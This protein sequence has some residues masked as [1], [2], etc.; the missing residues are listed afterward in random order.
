MD[1]SGNAYVTGLTTSID[2]PTATAL[3][4][5][6]KGYEN[7]FAIKLSATGAALVYST[8]LG[9]SGSDSG[10]AI[11][12]DA[13]GNAYVTGTTCSYDFPTANAFQTVNANPICGPWGGTAFVSKLSA[14]PA[15]TDPWEQAISAMRTAA[16]TDSL[17]FWQWAWY[18]QGNTPAFSGAPAG[19]GVAGSISPDLMAQII[20]QPAAATRF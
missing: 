18:W 13:S 19:F 14:F 3:Q 4:S 7:A 17:N 9:G 16:G 8:F 6:L 1:S 10:H 2:F 15:I 20:W 12:L 11:A 5:A